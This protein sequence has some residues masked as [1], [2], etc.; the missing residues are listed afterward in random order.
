[1]WL[2]GLVGPNWFRTD[3]DFVQQ[4]NIPHITVA[5]ILITKTH[6]QNLQQIAEE[7]VGELEAEL[8]SGGG[9]GLHSSAGAPNVSLSKQLSRTSSCDSEGV[10]N[11][12]EAARHTTT[13]S[14]S[15]GAGKAAIG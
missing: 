11:S 7:C 5:K 3:S 9:G 12:D 14:S 13:T 15:T 8:E 1:M 2:A 10:D 4:N 6:N